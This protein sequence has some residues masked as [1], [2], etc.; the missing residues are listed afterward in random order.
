MKTYKKD[1]VLRVRFWDSGFGEQILGFGVQGVVFSVS[2]GLNVRDLVFG[3]LVAHLQNEAQVL[4]ENCHKCSCIICT[5]M[6]HH[7]LRDQLRRY[8]RGP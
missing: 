3:V 6:S 5:S 1:K 8:M 7:C 4:V 2:L